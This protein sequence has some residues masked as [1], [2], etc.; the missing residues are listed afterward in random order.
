MFL[1]KKLRIRWVFSVKSDGQFK[2]RLLV[3]LGWNQKYGLVLIV[4]ARCLYLFADFDSQRLLLATAATQMVPGT[5]YETG[6]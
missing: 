1:E 6:K 3:V 2:A 5:I 4:E